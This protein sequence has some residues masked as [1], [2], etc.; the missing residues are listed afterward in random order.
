[1]LPLLLVGLL[2]LLLLVLLVLQLSL[3]VVVQRAVL[4]GLVRLHRVRRCL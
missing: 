3:S 2:V 4:I 1:L